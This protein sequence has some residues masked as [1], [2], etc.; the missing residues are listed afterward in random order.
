MAT[1]IG[2]L[3]HDDPQRAVRLI[4]DHLDEAPIWPE[5][6]RRSFYEE[7]VPAHTQDLP[8]R[9]IDPDSK[10]IYLDTS[11]GCAEELADFY[12]RALE[13]KKTEDFSGF[14]QSDKYA[15][16][17]Q[18]T[19][20]ALVATDRKYPI[21]KVHCIGPV[22]FQLQLCDQN[23][24]S[25]YYDDTFQDVLA[26]QVAAQ[27]RWMVKQF[28]PYADQVLAFLDEP[29]LAAFGS[30]AYIGILREDV[31]ERLARV[32]EDIKKEGALVG[33]HV[34]GNTD[35][36]MVIEAGA[37]LIN[38]DAYGFGP[39]MLVYAKEI[40]EFMNRGG[41]LA[42]GI[43]P[44]NDNIKTESVADLENKFFELVEGLS[45]LGVDKKLVL[46]Q[47]MITPSCGMG[48]MSEKDAELVVKK[49]SQLAESIQQV[50]R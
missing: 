41:I 25:L 45:S 39:S 16:A 13:A 15:S 33:V 10:K 31:I 40:K 11:T 24:K 37:D 6:P 42:W 35:W 23:G 44:T 48:T 14:A 27:T 32:I 18:E 17:L 36:P 46:E 2:S 4:L 19:I 21:V 50:A 22:S 20:R 9:V 26:E 30:S 43:V 28:T 34:C 5:L 7:F 12:Q 29:G 1:M 49:L 8:C 3:P 47:S 38:Y